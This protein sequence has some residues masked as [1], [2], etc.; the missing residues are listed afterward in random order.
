MLAGMNSA[1]TSD[2]APTARPA[3]RRDR[4]R[5][6]L[7]GVCSGVART[8]DV[9]PL[10]VRAI[11]IVVG[12]LAGPLALVAYVASAVIMPRDDGRMVLATQPPDRR[13]LWIGWA[14]VVLAAGTLIFTGPVID[15]FWDG[16][17]IGTPLLAIA[18][19]A[20]VVVLY[21]ANRDRQTAPAPTMTAAAADP[22]TA[23]TAV[24]EPDQAPTTTMPSAALPATRTWAPRGNTPPAHSPVVPKP[25]GP[26]IFLPVAGALLAVAAVATVID[27][28]GITDVSADA[29][30]V[31]LAAGALVCGGAAAL[32][33]GMRGRIVTLL[34]GVVLAATAAGTAI[35]A[36]QFDDGVGAR[37]IRPATAADIQP[38]YKL[39]LGLL[40]LDFRD[41][42]FPPGVTTV[43]AHVGAGAIQ[44]EVPDDV[45]IQPVGDTSTS[46]GSLA[47]ITPPKKDHNA[48]ILRIDADI[49]VGGSVEVGR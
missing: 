41:V 38:E 35:L 32:A 40:D 6:M 3:L 43:K 37:H 22:P 31:M 15:G 1:P 48:P 33:G 29:I 25:S 24:V 11:V 21:R 30:A 10:L 12:L 47:P 36:P 8:L 45:Q 9:D 39:G 20:G 14:G 13:E 46:G 17:P 19:I 7:L 42:D 49:D 26:S 5:G 28:V 23:P 27:A 34:L 18:L 44:L 16:D 2:A 4:E